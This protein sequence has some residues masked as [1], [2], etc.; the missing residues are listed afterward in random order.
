M[1]RSTVFS[2]NRSQAVRLPKR[3][4]LPAHVRKVEI[5]RLGDSRVISPAD[6]AWDVFFSGPKVSEDFLAAR[7]QPA[8]QKR[9]RP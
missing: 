5:T 3:V 4:A 7:Q 2:N 9:S 1:A 6:R 8:P